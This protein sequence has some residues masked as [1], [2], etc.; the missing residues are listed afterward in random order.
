MKR[1]SLKS[2]P[3]ANPQ[4]F[5]RNS[6]GENRQDPSFHHPSILIYDHNHIF[7]F[8]R[9]LII[10]DE[11]ERRKKMIL[12]TIEEEEEAKLYVVVVGCRHH[13]FVIQECPVL[14]ENTFKWRLEIS[15]SNIDWTF[16]FPHII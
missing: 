6:L 4:Q 2:F 8:S 11:E 14:Q 13:N 5:D 16:F 10:M 7:N 3:F 9:I 15:L 1:A 12:T